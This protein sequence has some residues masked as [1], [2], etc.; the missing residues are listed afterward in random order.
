MAHTKPE[1][2]DIVTYANHE[3]ITPDQRSLRKA[4]VRA[5]PGDEDPV[6]HAEKALAQLS[7]EYGAWMHEECELLD[8]GRHQVK[9]TGFTKANWDALFSAAHD[10]KGNA[11]TF[12]YPKAAPAA[13]SLCRLLEHTPDMT[14][15]PLQLIDQHVDAIRA[16]VREHGR[17]DIA[18]IEA[19]LI[20]RLR[21]VTE[22]FLTLE[23]RHR[24]D[25]LKAMSSPP[26]SPGE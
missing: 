18:E 8:A 19:V 6:E 11:E 12:G 2:P 17:P 23:N 9:E 13:D 20:K 16:I 1:K 14:K 24:P 3:V 4:A 10:V 26:L 25:Y 15:I 21:Q 5:R 22:E 7:N